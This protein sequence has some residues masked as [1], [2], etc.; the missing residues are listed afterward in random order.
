M[1]KGTTSGLLDTPKAQSVFK[2]AILDGYV[3]PFAVMTA[4]KIPDRRAVLL[5][6][7]AGRGRYDDGRPA[8]AEYLLRAAESV[9]NSTKVEVF[10][11]ERSRKDFKL[12][13]AVADEY[14]QRGVAV[15]SRQGVVQDHLQE[16]LTRATGAPLF[17]FLDPC[18]A[19]LPF[20]TLSK[21]LSHDRR[22]EWP[23][24]EALLNISAELTRRAAGAVA[25]GLTDH[26][27]VPVMNAMCGGAWWQETAL[28]AHSTS[29]T[30][31]WESAA[32]AVVDEY[33]R[34]LAQAC[35]M[36]AVV[37]P[38]RRKA[39]HQPVYHLVFLT[40]MNYGLWVFADAAAKARHKWLDVLGPS[41][42]EVEGMLFDMVADQIESET[43]ASFV[44]IKDNLRKLAAQG[45]RQ[46]L[47]DHTTAVFEGFYGTALEKTVRKAMRELQTE[48]VAVDA[49]PKQLRDWL[50]G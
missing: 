35:R 49:K 19:N 1:S 26:D 14:R 17:L 24:T 44:K 12:L 8:S 18:G 2:H 31:D 41:D 33:A 9:S 15:E 42:E 32:E 6:G 11:V 10:L 22:T 40:R 48:G 7:F 4:S 29:P 38:V 28:K 46:K 45:R 20:E 34:R 3:I 43:E 50:I 21:I 47:V 27:A 39:H 13:A 16:V 36:K 37:A 30:S 5:D 25:K 23:R